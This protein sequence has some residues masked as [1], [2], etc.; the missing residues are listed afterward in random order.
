MFVVIYYTH[1]LPQAFPRPPHSPHSLITRRPSAFSLPLILD[2]SPR[3]TIGVPDGPILDHSQASPDSI[4]NPSKSS[5]PK[6][7]S[8]APSAMHCNALIKK[9]K[10][11]KKYPH[12]F[13][14]FTK[15][16]LPS[17]LLCFGSVRLGVGARFRGQEEKAY[18]KSCCKRRRDK[19]VV[20]KK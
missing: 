7:P 18:V 20:F 10:Q 16:T 13:H 17:P 4:P 5:C 8:T 12:P 19:K 14:P 2:E 11:K 3:D 1:S 6:M 15:T 9:K